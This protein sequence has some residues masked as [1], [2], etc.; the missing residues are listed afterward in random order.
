MKEAHKVLNIPNE[1]FV[2]PEGV[3]EVEIDS[4]TKQL[5]TSRTKK[6]EIEVFLKNNQPRSN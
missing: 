3:V 1:P 4:D 6:T 5:P 2:M